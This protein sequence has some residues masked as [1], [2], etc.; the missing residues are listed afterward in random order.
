MLSQEQ[1]HCRTQCQDQDQE[2]EYPLRNAPN[3]PDPCHRAAEDDRHHKQVESERLAT[4]EA[5]CGVDG[6][7]GVE[8]GELLEKLQTLPTETLLG[9]QA[10]IDWGG[11]GR[12]DG[13][14]VTRSVKDAII[15]RGARLYDP[16][17][18]AAER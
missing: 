7:L 14:V 18:I 13:T 17:E 11:P 10:A 5:V 8:E 1:G 16:L 3:E 4:E 15:D 6:Q 2:L 9:A 12:I